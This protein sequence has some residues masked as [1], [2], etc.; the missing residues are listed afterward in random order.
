[1]AQERN[2]MQRTGHKDNLPERCHGDD[3]VPE[4]LG[5]AGE[6]SFRL[7]LLRVEHYCRKHNDCHR[8]REQK[9]AEF[10]GARLECV[11]EDSETLRVTRELKHTK[12][13]EHTQ[14]DECSTEVLI[15]SHHQTD[16]VGQDS[17]DIDDAHDARHVVTSVGRREQP[18]QVLDGEDDDAG[19][20]EAE[21]FQTVVFTTRLR[22][23]CAGNHAAR[24]CLDHIGAHWHGDEKPSHV[25]EH[26]R[27]RAGVR[28]LERTPHSL[29]HSQLHPGGRRYRQDV[30][31]VVCLVQIIRLT[32]GVLKLPVAIVFQT[33][34][35]HGVWMDAEKRQFF[36]EG[37]DAVVTREVN[38]SG[39][40]VGQ[41]VA[42]QFR[43][44][45][46][47]VLG[48]RWVIE[49][50]SLVR[51]EQRHRELVEHVTPRLKHVTG[52][53]DPHA[54]SSAAGGRGNGGGRF[55]EVGVLQ[56]RRQRIGGDWN[57]AHRGGAYEWKPR[58][59]RRHDVTV[60]RVR[61]GDVKVSR[62]PRNTTDRSL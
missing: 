49:I 13:S 12:H 3:G 18:Q 38:A 1:M 53:I 33:A 10:T 59:H 48:G 8:Q 28:K 21:Q 24:H 14:R 25:V 9:K 36:V 43:V 35:G 40:V 31:T 56:V 2:A 17:D 11:A 50:V 19:C 37:G 51:A 45:V 62:R 41:D 26:E 46:E 47:E 55:P 52:N 6:C 27:W 61:L 29:T 5:D 23:P 54:I 34:V 16:V 42:E 15:V 39:A 7:I 57:P 30:V 20:V 32:L 58:R 44:T 4:R 60:D 22:L